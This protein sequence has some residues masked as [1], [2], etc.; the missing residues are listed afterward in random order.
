MVLTLTNC[1]D[2]ILPSNILSPP[3][4]SLLTPMRYLIIIHCNVLCAFEAEQLNSIRM[5]HTAV[6][7]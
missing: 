2:L 1:T 7:F 4:M 5:K 6:E 3:S